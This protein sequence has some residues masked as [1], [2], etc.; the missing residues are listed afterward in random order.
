[1]RCLG[2]GGGGICWEESGEGLPA[3]PCSRCCFEEAGEAEGD[4]EAAAAA[5]A[6]AA[7]FCGVHA[8]YGDQ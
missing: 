2:G 7:S 3:A 1:L 6:A 8:A 5:V 4:W